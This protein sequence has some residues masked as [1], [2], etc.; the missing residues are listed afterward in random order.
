[1]PLTMHAAGH[2]SLIDE[3]QYHLRYSIGNARGSVSRQDLLQALGYAIRGRLIDGLIES[4][5]RRR[6]SKAK[7]LLYLSAEFLIGQSL[8]DNSLQPGSV[9]GGGA[10]NQAAGL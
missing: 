9:A 3:I 5:E 7:R 1:M 4:E 2:E 6:L 8:R 10:D